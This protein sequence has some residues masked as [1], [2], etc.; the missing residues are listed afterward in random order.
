MIT[1]DEDEQVPLVIVHLNTLSPVASELTA[2]E[3]LAGLDIFPLPL[4][5]DQPPVPFVGVL[6]AKVADGD[7]M[8]IFC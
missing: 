7:V 2:D 1:S 5:L 4:S 8:Q 3:G 6:A